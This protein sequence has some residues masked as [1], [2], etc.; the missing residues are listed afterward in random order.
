MSAPFRSLFQSPRPSFAPNT[1]SK[2]HR[3]DVR[4]GS[5]VHMGVCGAAVR[6][7][8]RHRRIHLPWARRVH[9]QHTSSA[10]PLAQ[11]IWERTTPTPRRSSEPMSPPPDHGT[12]TSRR[13]RR[14]LEGSHTTFHVGRETDLVTRSSPD[15]QR[16]QATNPVG[17]INGR[18]RSLRLTKKR[19]HHRDPRLLNPSTHRSNR[20]F[21]PRSDSSNRSSRWGCQTRP[22]WTAMMC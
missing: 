2:L 7:V 9:R 6:R 3:R 8:R 18:R 19:N 1:V 15:S 20:R 4:K 22:R 16:S 5:L 12:L 17:R 14:R 10:H 13:T 21:S 11:R